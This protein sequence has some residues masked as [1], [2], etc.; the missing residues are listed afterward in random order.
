MLEPLAKTLG[1]VPLSSTVRLRKTLTKRHSLSDGN[2]KSCRK[3][4]TTVEGNAHSLEVH[5]TAEENCRSDTHRNR[6]NDR[7]AS[8]RPRAGPV[9]IATHSALRTSTTLTT[10]WLGTRGNCRPGQRPSFTSESL[11]RMPQHLDSSQKP[12]QLWQA[13]NLTRRAVARGT[14]GRRI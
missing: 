11:W 10:L 6:R 9:S 14:P 3:R 2:L 8:A 7:H 4:V 1:A 12:F 13:A 5:L